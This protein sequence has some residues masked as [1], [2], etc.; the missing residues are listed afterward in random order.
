[1]LVVLKRL[2]VEYVDIVLCHR[3]DPLT[4]TEYVVRA[5]TDLIRNG[6]AMACG[7]SEWSAQQITEA[8]WLARQMNME[9]PTIEQPQYNMYTREKMEAEFTPLFLPPYNLGTTTWSPL[10][11]GLLTGKYNKGT[12]EGCRLE[13]GAFKAFANVEQWRATG[14]LGTVNRLTEYANEKLGCSM[15]QLA[16]AWCLKNKKVSTALLGASKPEQLEHNLGA[17]AVARK[18]TAED[19]EMLDKMLNSKPT[20]FM[21]FGIDMLPDHVPPDGRR[22]QPTFC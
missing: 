9:P 11:C 14:K 17:V 13:K 1:M 18:L 22:A 16:I 15:T 12:P 5:M 3:P 2:K 20:P 7:T 6:T 21:G 19:M 10:S 4:P 8:Y